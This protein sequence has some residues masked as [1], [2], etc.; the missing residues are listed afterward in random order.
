MS[1]LFLTNLHNVKLSCKIKQL[2]NRN[3]NCLFCNCYKY[4]NLVH[5]KCTRKYIF[6]QKY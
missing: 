1:Q 3:N 6:K 2:L 5:Y 4:L